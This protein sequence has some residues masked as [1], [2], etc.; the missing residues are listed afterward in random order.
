MVTAFAILAMFLLATTV[1]PPSEKG[2]QVETEKHR[3]TAVFVDTRSDPCV[4][5][6]LARCERWPVS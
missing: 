3:L 2:P 1:T 4:N 6:Q 5:I